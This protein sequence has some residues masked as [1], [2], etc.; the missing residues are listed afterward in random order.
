MFLTWTGY[1]IDGSDTNF[2]LL[3]PENQQTLDLVDY[4]IN[5]PI[6]DQGS[7][8]FYNHNRKSLNWGEFKEK[9][10]A[11]S[12]EPLTIEAKFKPFE[13]L[14]ELTQQTFK[15]IS[16]KREPLETA[17]TDISTPASAPIRNAG[18]MAFEI[19]ANAKYMAGKYDSYDALGGYEKNIPLFLDD[20]SQ[21]TA[22]ELRVPVGS[23]Y[24]YFIYIMDCLTER[25]PSLATSGGLDCG[26]GWTGGCTYGDSLYYYKKHQIPLQ[27][28]IRHFLKN[29]TSHGTT[30][31][32]GRFFNS[33]RKRIFDFEL[34]NNEEEKPLKLNNYVDYVEEQLQQASNHYD[35]VY[36]TACHI[37]L[38]WPNEFKSDM[39]IYEALLPLAEEMNKY[40]DTG[41]LGF[42]KE[43]NTYFAE[44][45]IS[46]TLQYY[47]LTYLDLIRRDTF[48]DIKEKMYTE[49]QEFEKNRPLAYQIIRKKKGTKK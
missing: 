48:A 30:S 42:Y 14:D 6:F 40:N 4:F 5:L 7:L 43:G 22:F 29:L 47:F 45:C 39:P 11:Y 16:S 18:M 9:L 32:T 8:R 25:F 17:Y 37:W 36:R 27:Y 33:I 44:F 13:T 3:L 49:R 1:E 15:Q 26:G 35:A 21:A 41:F 19:M 20:F 46:T 31:Y 34:V 2:D 23:I 24:E 38:P 10:L 28:G 12:T